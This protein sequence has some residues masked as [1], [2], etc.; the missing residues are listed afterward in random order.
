MRLHLF[1]FLIL[2]L[3]AI[4]F[5]GWAFLAPTQTPLENF[6]VRQTGGAADEVSAAQKSAANALRVRLP[7]ARVDFD[8]ITGSPAMI[9]GIDQFLAV[10]AGVGRTISSAAR[11][12]FPGSDPYGV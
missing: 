5:D 10:P 11:A 1:L 6:D 3:V 4:A 12:A 9:S 7:H 8:Q 2:A